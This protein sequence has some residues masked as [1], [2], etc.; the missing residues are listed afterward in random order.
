[1]NPKDHDA[2]PKSRLGQ[3]LGILFF[4]IVAIVAKVFVRQLPLSHVTG[5]LP[6]VIPACASFGPLFLLF[7]I[8]MRTSPKAPESKWAATSLLVLG[9]VMITLALMHILSKL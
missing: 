6:P 4:V 3:W 5:M 1:M 7:G 2:P 8:L 9:T